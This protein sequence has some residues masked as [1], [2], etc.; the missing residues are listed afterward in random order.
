MADKLANELDDLEQKYS[1][2]VHNALVNICSEC[3]GEVAEPIGELSALVS[4]YRSRAFYWFARCQ[5]LE[6]QIKSLEERAKAAEAQTGA[7]AAL[8]QAAERVAA[9]HG[10]NGQARRNAIPV[11]AAPTY[12]A[13]TNPMEERA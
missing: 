11:P 1:T 13:T 10:A 3:I 7:L 4:H 9:Q 6:E 2:A 8:M 12:V 5:A